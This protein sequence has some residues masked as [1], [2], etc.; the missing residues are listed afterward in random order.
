[1][2]VAEIFTIS[3]AGMSQFRYTDAGQN[4]S[5][6]GFTFSPY[7][8]NRGKIS[9]STDLKTDETH[10]TMAKNWGTE[11]AVY[12]DIMAGAT[13]QIHRINL[14]NTEMESVLLFD[15]EVSDTIVD[16]ATIDLRCTTLD[17]LNL[18]LPKRELQVACNW[19]LFGPYCGITIG[20]YLVTSTGGVDTVDPDFISNPA[21]LVGLTQHLRG[22]FVVGLCGHNTHITRHIINH[23]GSQVAVLPPF[24][25]DFELTDNVRVAPG[26]E[27]DVDVCEEK[28]DNLKNFGGFPYIPNYDQ[29]F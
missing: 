29:V 28:F 16:E 19:Q 25:F 21:F 12:K 10:V 24:P 6:A 1:M 27:H 26:C 22:G 9:F 8:I 4:V 2:T 17:F 20:D 5:F 18:E 7:P 13:V 11:M 3:A 23:Y 14:D 15:G